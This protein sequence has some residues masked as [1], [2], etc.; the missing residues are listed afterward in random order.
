M[1]HLQGEG[2]EEPCSRLATSRPLQIA[3]I[4]GE[5]LP[6][7]LILGSLRL[8]TAPPPANFPSRQILGAPLRGGGLFPVSA[9]KA[10]KG[11]GVIRSGPFHRSDDDGESPQGLV[12]KGAGS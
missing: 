11:G 8:G 2:R 6:A 9:G 4:L 10:G 12:P 7:P 3:E 1:K 5:P